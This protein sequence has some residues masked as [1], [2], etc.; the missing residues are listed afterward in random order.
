MKD[1]VI[2]LVEA[3]RLARLELSCYRNPECAAS[4]DWTVDR[5]A[6]LLETPQV[7]RAMMALAPDAESPPLA[8]RQEDAQD[9]LPWDND[10]ARIS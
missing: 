6:E 3:V 5:L 2:A 9:S 7:T 8:P 10:S 1:H 4:P